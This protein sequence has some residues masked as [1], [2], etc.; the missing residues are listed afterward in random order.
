MKGFR[1]QVAALL[2]LKSSDQLFRH[3]GIIRA[4]ATVVGRLE[5]LARI[6]LEDFEDSLDLH[7]VGVWFGFGH[8]V[9]IDQ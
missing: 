4:L 7:F 9:F 5:Q 3:E 6:I 8:P 2:Q 1:P